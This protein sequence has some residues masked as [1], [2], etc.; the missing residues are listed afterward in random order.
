M[1]A[2]GVEGD[3]DAGAIRSNMFKVEWP[4]RS[5]KW[6]EFPEVDRA[7]FFD[8]ETASRKINAAQVPFLLEVEARLSGAGGA[9]RS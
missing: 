8:L 9:G 4:P 3:L 6:E 1:V 2:F 5:G 7:D